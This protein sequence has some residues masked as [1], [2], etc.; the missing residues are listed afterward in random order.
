MKLLNLYSIT[1]CLSLGYSAVIERTTSPMSKEKRWSVSD[2][3]QTGSSSYTVTVISGI[4]VSTA[5][6]QCNYETGSDWAGAFAEGVVNYWIDE[7][8][9]IRDLIQSI[10]V[11]YPTSVTT[12]LY[13]TTLAAQFVF[14]VIEHAEAFVD[15]TRDYMNTKRSV[16]SEVNGSVLELPNFPPVKRDAVSCSNSCG[17]DFGGE[18]TGICNDDWGMISQHSLTCQI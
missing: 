5:L 4:I 2:P 7:E 13:C 16:V 15:A 10:D 17:F 14:G 1:T 11:Y 3:K 8:F 18:D 6:G 9:G 12:E